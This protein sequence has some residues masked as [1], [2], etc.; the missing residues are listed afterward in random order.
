MAESLERI[1]RWLSARID[2]GEKEVLSSVRI[3]NDF[4][5]ILQEIDLQVK[6]GVSPVNR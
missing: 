4:C 3:E 5:M 6:D 1:G 2:Q